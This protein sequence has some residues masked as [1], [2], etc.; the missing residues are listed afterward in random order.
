MCTSADITF[1][2]TLV[3]SNSPNRNSISQDNFRLVS[4]ITSLNIHKDEINRLGSLR[5]AVKTNQELEHFYSEDM[6]SSMVPTPANSH[7]RKQ[8]VRTLLPLDV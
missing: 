3:S 4:I 2:W 5:Y 8:R 7:H 1:L 6:I